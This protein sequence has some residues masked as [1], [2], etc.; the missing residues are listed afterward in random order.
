MP[1][2][3][4]KGAPPI[5]LTSDW[6]LC[7]AARSWSLVR[8][9]RVRHRGR[10]ERPRD[11]RLLRR[12]LQ[13]LQ[14]DDCLLL[15]RGGGSGLRSLRRST[16]ESHQTGGEGNIDACG[17]RLGGRDG[18]AAALLLAGNAVSRATALTAMDVEFQASTATRA[19]SSR[20][21]AFCFWRVARSRPSCSS[22]ES[23]SPHSVSTYFPAGL[24]GQV[25]QPRRCSPC[26]RFVGFLVLAPGTRFQRCTRDPPQRYAISP[27]MIRSPRPALTRLPLGLTSTAVTASHTR[28]MSEARLTLRDGRTLAWHEYGPADG[29]PHLRF[30]GTPGSRY[31]RHPHE[32][33][34]DRHQVRVILFDRPGYGASSRLPGRGISAVAD[35]AAELLDHLGL[36]VVHVAGGSGGGPHALAFAARHPE[37]VRAMTVV[38]GGAPLE[39]ADLSEMIE[40][41]RD[42]VVRGA[43]ELG[44]AACTDRPHTRTSAGRSVSRIPRGDGGCA[45]ERQGSDERPGVAA[46]H[47]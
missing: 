20:T 38:V 46:R 2:R 16:G 30:Q 4:R 9:L 17:R 41:N 34:Y 12:Q 8:R 22:A 37:R 11:P 21:P 44:C 31:S 7:R 39:E 23:H 47:D 14:G 40:L 5:Q 28:A 29:R 13:S 6:R 33:S 35:D 19:V 32:D 1:L 15:D 3:E 10:P 18:G 42:G 36:D 27:A 25:S 45:R 24:A 26:G 43:R